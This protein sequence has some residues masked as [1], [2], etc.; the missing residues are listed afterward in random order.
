MLF[1]GFTVLC[2]LSHRHFVVRHFV[3]VTRTYSDSLYYDKISVS[4][5]ECQ[6]AVLDNTVHLPQ[7]VWV[8]DVWPGARPW[9][10][11]NSSWWWNQQQD[12][13]PTNTCYQV[14]TGSTENKPAV[15]IQ[16]QE[17]QNGTATRCE[18][19]HLMWCSGGE[20]FI[21]IFQLLV[22]SKNSLS[23]NDSGTSRFCWV[24]GFWTH[25]FWFV[26]VPRD[27][28]CSSDWAFLALWRTHLLDI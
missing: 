5:D 12:N 20:N 13:R 28:K 25:F 21:T 14:Y 26:C 18:L 15:C 6:H 9:Q 23:S 3:N 19:M 16:E 17:T 10:Q 22:M 8:S 4:I 24:K 11:L 7:R 2:F 27:F 1:F